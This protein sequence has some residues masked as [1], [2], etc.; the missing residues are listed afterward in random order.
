[1]NMNVNI[2]LCNSEKHGEDSN[3]ELSDYKFLDLWQK[4]LNLPLDKRVYSHKEVINAIDD[5]LDPNYNTNN[6]LLFNLELIKK[7]EDLCIMGFCKPRFFV[8]KIYK[9]VKIAMYN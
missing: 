4:Y 2:S 3:L 1:M 6:N 8:C 7:L 9:Y 5:K